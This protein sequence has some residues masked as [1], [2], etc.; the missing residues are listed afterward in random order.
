MTSVKSKE[1]VLCCIKNCQKKIQK[2]EALVIDG[3]Y[4][5]KVC[6]VHYYRNML[7]F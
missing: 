7:E 5:C 4:F 1:T 6:G 3:K 2:D